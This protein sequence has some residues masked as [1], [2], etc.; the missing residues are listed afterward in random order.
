MRRSVWSKRIHLL[1]GICLASVQVA[2]SAGEPL[3][4]PACLSLEKPQPRLAEGVRFQ[5]AE[6]QPLPR[7]QMTAHSALTSSHYTE[8]RDIWGWGWG[9]LVPLGAPWL[10]FKKYPCVFKEAPVG[11]AEG[12]RLR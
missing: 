2:P 1:A 12:G 7:P 11:S 8:G 10:R 3:R 6:L 4:R 5:A 9:K